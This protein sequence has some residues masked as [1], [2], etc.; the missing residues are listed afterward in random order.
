MPTFTYQGFDAAGT[1][2]KGEIMAGSTEEVE[3]RLAQQNVTPTLIVAA[4]ARK[5]TERKPATPLTAGPKKAGGRRK[6]TDADRAGLLRDMATMVA[7]GVPFVESLDA[8][9]DAQSRPSLAGPLR[10]IRAAIVE[11]GSI[12]SSVRAAGGLFPPLVSDVIGVAEK[13]GRLDDAL[14]NAAGYLERSADLRRKIVN[15]TMYPM[16][17]LGI[18]TV[19]TGVIVVFVIPQFHDLFAKMKADLP[20]TTRAMLAVGDFVQKKPLP[21][22]GLV[23]AAV[24]GLF[25]LFRLPAARRLVAAFALRVPG[26]GD[27][28]LRLGLARALR[29]MATLLGSNVPIMVALEHGARVAGVPPVAAALSS[30]MEAVR[31]GGNLSDA[32]RRAPCIPATVTQMVVVGER[33]GRLTSLLASSAEKM[34][35]DSDAR[36]KSLVSILEPI[37][38]LLMG[39]LV[40]GITISIISPIYSAVGQ[41]R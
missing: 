37:M 6:V 28:M 22:A 5:A 31:S 14:D 40:G 8:V 20:V 21:S 23:L 2:T 39:V 18:S 24:A 36:L 13:G 25:A 11:G 9:L 41:G 1:R 10:G 38:I 15:A 7:A 3:R 35:S 4:K 19:M 33:T 12:S 17:M 29:V 30:A 32:L 34:E 16:V 26:L 27:L